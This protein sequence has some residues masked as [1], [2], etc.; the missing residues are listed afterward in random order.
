MGHGPWAGQSGEAASSGSVSAS[1]S[2]SGTRVVDLRFR[3][4]VLITRKTRRRGIHQS[5][6]MAI[7]F[8]GGGMSQICPTYLRH[9][10]CPPA[11]FAS[12]ADFRRLRNFRCCRHPGPER[13]RQ[14]SE[15]VPLRDA[16]HSP[17][18]ESGPGLSLAGHP[19]YS[20]W[21]HLAFRLSEG[22][23][24]PSVRGSHAPDGSERSISSP[25]CSLSSSLLR[26]AGRPRRSVP[27]QTYRTAGGCSLRLSRPLTERPS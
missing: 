13:L 18:P 19:A 23:I 20:T 15:R 21:S 5:S 24:K 8:E 4:R 12:I 7:P 1:G 27:D 25:H 16:K 9:P 22:P 2:G 10:A 6:Q 3:E 17:T 26:R 11:G 14:S